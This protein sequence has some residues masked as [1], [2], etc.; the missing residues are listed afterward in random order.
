MRGGV[1]AAD[2]NADGGHMI[3]EIGHQNLANELVEMCVLFDNCFDLAGER[4]DQPVGK[5]DAQKG[6]DQRPAD[7]LAQHFGRLVDRTHGL[8]HPQH[9]RDDTQCR[10]AVG[11]CLQGMAGVQ[12][13]MEVRLH[14]FFQ[15]LLDLVR[16]VIVHGGGPDRVA[17]QVR[18]FPVFQ[19]ARIAPEDRGVLRLFYMLF[20]GHRILAR[21]PDQ[22]EEKAQKVAIVVRL[23]L[24]SAE[25]LAHIAHRV[26]DRTEIIADQKRPDGRATDHHHLERQ[27]FH[28]DLH[29]AAGEDITAENHDED[30]D[31]ADNADHLPFPPA[32]AC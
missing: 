9:R 1:L 31:D 6:A 5:E 3:M 2:L 30:Q 19:D 27:G 10:Q 4:S 8:D 28:D 26:F 22:R 32:I 15:H 14:P 12:G 20:D 11:H 21:H 17:D 23:P 16:V 18:G 25:N 24:G 7:Q 13:M 29:F